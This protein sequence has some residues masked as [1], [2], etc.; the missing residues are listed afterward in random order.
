MKKTIKFALLVCLTLLV[1]ALMFTACDSGNE[2]QT[3]SIT[4]DEST[5]EDSTTDGETDGT[6]EPETEAHVH[7]FGEW[8][9]VKESTCTA[10]GEQERT[11]SC[12]EKEKQN[13]DMVAHSEVADEAIKP[14]CTET[15]LTEGKHCSVCNEVLVAQETVASLGHTPGTAATC[16]D[17]QNCTVCGDKLVSSNGHAPGAAA[18]C[19]TNQICLVCQIELTPAYGHTPITDVAVAPTCTATGLTEGSHCSICNHVFVAQETVAAFGHTDVIDAAIAATCTATCTATG[20][21]EGK[22]CSV[23]N[24]VLIAQTTVAAKGH[25]EVTDEA[26]TPTCTATGLTEGKHCSV[27]E[28]I[29]TQQQVLPANGH[30][31]HPALPTIACTNIPI[32]YQCSTCNNTYQ[33]R[34]Q[35]ISADFEVCYWSYYDTN[36]YVQ[37][38]LIFNS[39]AGGYGKYSISITYTNVIGEIFNYSYT[40]IEDLQEWFF[41]GDCSWVQYIFWDYNKSSAHIVIT[42]E[43]GLSTTY[44]IIFPC[45]PSYNYLDDTN[46]YTSDVILDIQVE[47]T[48]HSFSEWKTVK[49]ATCTEKG[50]QERACS[51]GEKETQSIDT[52]AH[53]EVIDEAVAPSCVETGLMEG[54]HCSVCN[55]IIIAQTEIPANG[56]T[57]GGFITENYVDST[58]KVEGSY[59]EVVYCSV[60]EKE[61]SRTEKI[62]ELKE[63]I[64]VIDPAVSSTCTTTGKTEGKHC[65]ACGEIIIAQETV[66]V[67]HN[68]ESTY[69]H[70]QG[71]HWKTCSKCNA[72]DT[73]EAHVL[74]ADGYCKICSAPIAGS[75]GILYFISS[76]GTYAEV[77]DYVGDSSRI[78]IAKTY[79]G[80][81]VTHISDR[82]FEG[83]DISSIVIS[84]NIT[85]IGNYAFYQCS[86]L[87]SVTIGDHVT[88]IGE[89]AF[90]KC[91]NLQTIIIPD[92]VTH[93]AYRAFGEC[94]N[95]TS[96][97]IGNGITTISSYLFYKCNQ[98]TTVIV[99]NGVTSI[100]EA[101][102]WNCSSLRNITLPDTIT[103]IASGAF[104]GCTNAMEIVN[105]VSY[106]GPYL[107]GFDNSTALVSIREGTT[108]IADAAFYQCGKL[109]IITIPNTVAVIGSNAFVWCESLERIT[110]PNTITSIDA[111]MFKGCSKLISITIPDSVASIGEYAF[112]NCKSLTNIFLPNSVTSIGAYAF[113]N[114]SSLTS[115]TIP[116][117]VTSIGGYAFRG[118]SS[119]RS[120]TLPF[121][122]ASRDGATST[123]FGYI[124]GATAY[125]VNNHDIPDSLTTVVITDTTIIGGYAFWNCD[126]ITSITLPNNLTTIGYQA[127]EYC[128]G[129]SSITIPDSVTSISAYAFAECSNLTNITMSNNLTNIGK[130]AFYNCCSLANIT[131]P[132]S[133]INIGDR[134]F[135]NCSSLASITIPNSVTNIGE[136]AFAYACT[137]TTNLVI[138]DSVEQIGIGAFL[139]WNNLTS[140][141]I[142]FVGE[143]KNAITNSNGNV[144]LGHLFGAT[145]NSENGKYIPPTLKSVVITDS[146]SIGVRAFANCNNLEII[147]IS[148]GVTSIGSYAFDGCNSLT[149]ISLPNSIAS[150]DEYAFKGCSSLTSI[151]IPAGMTVIDTRAF[152]GFDG[153]TTVTIPDS[154]TTINPSAFSGCK[155]LTSVII[156]NGVT[157]IGYSAFSG[158]NNLTSI[159]IGNGVTDI[160]LTAFM[161]C[162]S[163]TTIYYSGAVTDWNKINIGSNN[164]YFKNATRYYYSETQPT[165]TTSNYWHY[166]DGVPTKW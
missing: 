118:C 99:G 117:S 70:N 97:T 3:P 95:L 166:A 79:E 64:E 162:N 150:I 98:L 72:I 86:A 37:D 18:T 54:K 140:I 40:N 81:P 87:T 113:E 16:T 57:N 47:A 52:V 20:L 91:Y 27:C 93:L 83:K 120:I 103:E 66:P 10:K 76:D 35:E 5:T 85:H 115:I 43:L 149:N 51:C 108:L 29:L 42:D 84:G 49:A 78:V 24:E 53:T 59:D 61:L 45:L 22:H 107:I 112:Y 90:S 92:N 23:C 123:L 156:G 135:Y 82:A 129:L 75:D 102:F 148:D 133:V 68:W 14:T 131:I 58:C 34:S 132:N 19:T 164:N 111:Y 89:Y 153:L 6:T 125:S 28:S 62:I 33:E 8:T 88:S 12:G 152:A 141:T 147:V 100:R 124:F 74:G 134:A 160:A 32:S 121:V 39:I 50:E 128:N 137:D 11:C 104:G 17:P 60:C 25:N 154:V 110:I 2:P 41:L 31:Y 119:L 77:I 122:G 4:T 48:C 38:V 144:H 158:C 157:D 26:V 21:T 73:E 163:L 96:V 143:Y 159:V 145:V 44:K 106:I 161:D 139:G 63:H 114:C 36:R 165:D 105:G 138:P 55:E 1:C 101:A 109:R 71:V 13:I 67:S 56:H 136:Y 146:T 30:D 151:V 7:S 9:T 155:N 65:D 15:G 116:N 80:L 130:Y 94:S 142:P 69:K 127:F 126:S 46:A